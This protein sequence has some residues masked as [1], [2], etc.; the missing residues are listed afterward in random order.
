MTSEDVEADVRKTLPR[1]LKHD[2]APGDAHDGTAVIDMT[3]EPGVTMRQRA[4]VLIATQS[5]G[6]ADG[7]VRVVHVEDEVALSSG[8]RKDIDA[9][10]LLAAAGATPSLTDATSNADGG[11]TAFNGTSEGGTNSAASGDMAH[12]PGGR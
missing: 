12:G 7:L 9:Q 11:L 1:E 5:A 6:T 2:I 8:H 3:M 4:K 10:T